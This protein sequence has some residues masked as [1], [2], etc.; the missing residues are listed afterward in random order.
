MAFKLDV[1]KESTN[2]KIAALDAKT[3]NIT[4]KDG[5]M[6]P[7]YK[8]LHIK[9]SPTNSKIWYL[10]YNSP[11]KGWRPQ[12]LGRFPEIKFEEAVRIADEAYGWLEKGIDPFATKK[13]LTIKGN[14]GKASV[15]FPLCQDSC[16]VFIS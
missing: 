7:V 16:P 10:R 5:K 6:I 1:V 3:L 14:R 11:S 12:R 8:G 13:S 15:T 9:L 2:D 4:H